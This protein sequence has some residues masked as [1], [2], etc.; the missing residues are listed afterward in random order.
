ME[1]ERDKYVN[2]GKRITP[3]GFNAGY[4]QGLA[5][6]DLFAA[7]ALN[8]MLSHSTRY[9]PREGADMHWHDSIVKEAYELADAMLAEREKDE[10]ND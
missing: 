6:R 5:V 3:D 9:Q 1:Y 2:P 8:G 7:N 10:S 4:G